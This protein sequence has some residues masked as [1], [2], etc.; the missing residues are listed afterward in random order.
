MPEGRAQACNPL[1]WGHVT[2]GG[3]LVTGSGEQ[4]GH[5]GLL[6]HITAADLMQEGI[7]A[8]AMSSTSENPDQL[9]K[10]LVPHFH[11]SQIHHLFHAFPI[12]KNEFE[13]I[14]LQ[15]VFELLPSGLLTANIARTKEE[16]KVRAERIAAKGGMCIWTDGSGFKGG[17]STA[18]VVQD[19]S[20]SGAVD[21]VFIHWVPAHI[22]IEGNKAVNA[23]AKE[24]AQG[25]TTPLS[26]PNCLLEGV[27]PLSRAAA[28]V[29]GAHAFCMRWHAEWSQSPRHHGLAPRLFDNPKPSSATARMLNTYLYRFHLAPSLDCPLCLVP[30]TVSHFLPLCPR[31]RHQCLSLIMRLGTACLSLHRL[32]AAKTD[33]GPVLTYARNTDCLPRTTWAPRGP[34]A[35]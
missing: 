17:V 20:L 28:I 3:A 15:R 32:L 23:R 29:A 31:F 6:D 2:C 10:L 33:H 16:A 34:H 35:L 30:E 14:D 8:V 12:F 22:G 5:G 13:T 11:R 27:L 24:A 19:T 7:P 9:L 18:A 26:T 25:A 1:L 4:R 21:W